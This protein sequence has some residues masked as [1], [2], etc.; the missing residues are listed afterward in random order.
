MEFKAIFLLGFLTDSWYNS[1][2]DCISLFTK[3]YNDQRF[4]VTGAA[5]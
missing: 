4:C 1:R 5:L 3:I 2:Y